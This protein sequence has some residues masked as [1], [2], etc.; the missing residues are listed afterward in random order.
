MAKRRRATTAGATKIIRV[1]AVRQPAPII[2][3]AAPRPPARRH[4]RRR[5]SHGGGGGGGLVSNEN[6]QFAVG[7]ALYGF[8][9]KS[10]IIAK[11]PEIPVVGR[12]GTAAIILD[13]WARHGGGRI[14][15]NAAR[16]AAVLAGYQLGTE[17]KIQG[18]DASTPGSLAGD[19]AS[20]D[21]AMGDEA[22][23]DGEGY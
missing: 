16:A 15:H 7:G 21:F 22:S 10:G 3:V 19:E 17:G 9:V 5:R 1:G 18:T 2:R 6:F 4:H 11:L 12:T 8:A 13:Y 23:G 20:G 14:V